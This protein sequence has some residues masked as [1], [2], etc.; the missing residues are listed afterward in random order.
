MANFLQYVRDGHYAGTIFHRVVRNSSSR[1]AAWPRLQ[2]KPAARA[3][4]TKRATGS[5]TVAAR[6]ASRGRRAARRHAQFY[7]NL[8]DNAA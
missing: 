3:C 5:A 1:A 2:E 7:V 6:L 8:A 4:P